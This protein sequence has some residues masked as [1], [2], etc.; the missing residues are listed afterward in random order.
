M[1]IANAPPFS[2]P[3]DKISSSEK[4]YANLLTL[5]FTISAV[6]LEKWSYSFFSMVYIQ[7][8]FGYNVVVY[9]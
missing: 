9:S 7:I 8:Y 5:P 2:K 1:L 4:I 3:M 6:M